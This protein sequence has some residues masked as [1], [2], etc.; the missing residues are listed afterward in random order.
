MLAQTIKIDLF[1][2]FIITAY[3]DYVGYKK[4]DLC[5]RLETFRDQSPT[6]Y[7]MFRGLIKLARAMKDTAQ[8]VS[9]ITGLLQLSASGDA[10]RNFIFKMPSLFVESYEP[11]RVLTE[12]IVSS[13]SSLFGRY[14]P[15]YEYSEYMRRNCHM[16]KVPDFNLYYN[17]FD[18]HQKEEEE[19][20]AEKKKKKEEEEERDRRR[21][22]NHKPWGR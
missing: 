6:E 7:D 1:T 3:G 4:F 17:L 14:Q 10:L 16:S 22:R 18:T 13:C 2:H 9:I 8:T 19:E 11:G 21:R 20:K 15:V 5:L 12:R